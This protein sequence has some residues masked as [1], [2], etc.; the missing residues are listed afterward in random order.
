MYWPANPPRQPTA[1]Y[2]ISLQGEVITVR[3]ILVFMVL[4]ILVFFPLSAPASDARVAGLW[5]KTTHPDPRNVTIFYSDDQLVKAIGYGRIAGKPAL[6]YAE[7]GL[8]DGQ[9]K[10]KYHYSSDATPHGWEPE[11]TMQLKL[12]KEGNRLFGMATSRSGAWSAQIEFRRISPR[13]K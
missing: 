5:T 6:W 8:R 7:G 11:G 4:F 9:V 1:P 3:H 2:Q 12:S 13:A 10:L